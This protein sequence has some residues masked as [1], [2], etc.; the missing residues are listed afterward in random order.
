[1]KILNK[2]PHIG[3]CTIAIL[4]L[5]MAAFC[6][7]PV[8]ADDIGGIQM[9][10]A[11]NFDL[12]LS[13]GLTKYF[14][15]EG[16]GLNALH[17]TT[18]PDE[19]YGQVTTTEEHSGVFYLTNTGGRG[20]DDDMILM[21]AVNGTISD[22]FAVHIRA[23]GYRWTP[24]PVL[25]QPPTTDEIEYI[26][27]SYEG[28]ITRSDFAYRAQTWKPA[29]DNAPGNYPLYYGQDMSDTSNTFQL[30]FVDLNTGN[31]GANAMIPE[32][33]DNGAVKIEYE[34]EN[35]HG[36]ASFSTYGW[37]N[38]SNQGQG[39]SWTN[40]LSGAGSSGYA[41]MGVPESPGDF[42]TGGSG[43][44]TES[45]YLGQENSAGSPSTLN[46]SVS[47]LP[48]A[49]TVAPLEAGS[50][51]PLPLPA[52]D[53]NGTVREA[54]LYLFL[55]HSQQ[56]GT[57]Y[58][59]EPSFSVSIG[60]VDLSP[61]RTLTDREG[62]D[63][64]PLSAT[65][66]YKTDPASIASG[67]TNLMVRNTG[68]GDAVFTCDGGALLLT[69]EDPALPSI[70]YAVAECCDA[71][72]VDIAGGVFEGDAVTRVFFD[73]PGDMDRISDSRLQ[74]IST[75]GTDHDASADTIGFND[76]EWSGVFVRQGA[77]MSAEHLI[78]DAVF[79]TSNA[80]SAA[81][82]AGPEAAFVTRL[83]LLV[84]AGGEMDISETGSDWGG[85]ASA[86]SYLVED[87]VISK[88]TVRSAPGGAPASVS[89]GGTERPAGVPAAEGTVYAYRMLNL[90]GGSS[91]PLDMTV[92]FYVPASWLSE[93]GIDAD[94]ISL[95]EYRDGAWHSLRT[96]HLGHAD[97]EEE[98]LADAV[99]ASLLAIGS[100]ASGGSIG[101]TATATPLPV[102]TDVQQ[103]P[104]GVMVAL[105]ACAILILA[106]RR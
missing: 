9:P 65:L 94:G 52:T 18:D 104:M 82:D 57:G 105:G 48:I 4:V 1:M 5:I 74:V 59:T 12:I 14:K 43:G 79:P 86:R 97:G 106:K 102:D 67:G 46:G 81:T 72:G 58:G 68:S 87:A 15:F 6:I 62:G 10:G 56:K 7:A 35:L 20:F 99:T 61:E 84:Y 85:E 78:A 19:P 60:G 101:G 8:A 100:V 31:L 44:T 80:A 89:V 16:G 93:Q 24:T 71:I 39:I 28:T 90:N 92:R 25:N 34:I 66:I 29:G 54:T 98:Y 64:A 47:L 41:V 23:S 37:C 36:L 2:R 55:S 38:Q 17:I 95:Q 50:A 45:G 49:G 83:F 22:D 103:S 70:T 88:I 53:V 11:K 63:H 76:R 27:G 51:A 40:R 33:I 73:G 96:E 77:V 21:I 32:M 3:W 30:V 42:S 69:V 26:D 75:A 13:N 91:A